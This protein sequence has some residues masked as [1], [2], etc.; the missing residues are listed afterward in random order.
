MQC[1]FL[2]LTFY[3]CVSFH[4]RGARLQSTLRAV[5]RGRRFPPP[6]RTSA[7]THFNLTPL[8]IYLSGH[9]RWRKASV[10]GVGGPFTLELSELGVALVAVKFFLKQQISYSDVYFHVETHLSPFS[11][12]PLFLNAWCLFHFSLLFFPTPSPAVLYH[13]RHSRSSFITPHAQTHPWQQSG[14]GLSQADC[15]GSVEF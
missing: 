3:G 1:V 2:S 4:R 11:Q 14:S 10:C 5:S 6:A 15:S 8:W 13:R 7:G 12:V 9:Y